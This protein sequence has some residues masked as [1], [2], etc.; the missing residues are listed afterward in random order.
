M[1]VRRTT[2]Q[3][4]GRGRKGVCVQSGSRPGGGVFVRFRARRSRSATGAPP[5]RA[6]V[7]TSRSVNA[8]EFLAFPSEGFS[9]RWYVAFFESEAFMGSLFFSFRLAFFAT[10]VSTALGVAVALYVVR[11]TG[12]LARAPPV[13]K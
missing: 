2:K 1:G 13:L 6:V 9:L 11:L 10:V 5:T 3:G 12:A 8:G 7:E 4:S